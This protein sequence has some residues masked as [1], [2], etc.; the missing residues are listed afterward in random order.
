MESVSQKV[1]STVL[2]STV[3]FVIDHLHRAAIDWIGEL[4]CCLLHPGQTAIHRIVQQN[5]KTGLQNSENKVTTNNT[6]FA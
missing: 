6:R 4:H 5:D 2:F 3:P 1:N